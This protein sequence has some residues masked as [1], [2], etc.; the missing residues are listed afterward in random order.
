MIEEQFVGC[1]REWEVD[2][3]IVIDSNAHEGAHQLK[4]DV[5][6]EGHAV[7]P[8]ELHIFVVR[9]HAVLLTADLFHHKRKVLLARATLIDSWF[10]SE[11][12]H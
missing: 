12:H 3:S 4:V 1:S 8:V 6:L 2:E 7:D 10:P 11:A 5:H 9:E